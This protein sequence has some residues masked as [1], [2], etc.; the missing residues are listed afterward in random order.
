MKFGVWVKSRPHAVA[1]CSLPEG[2]LAH[3]QTIVLK[4]NWVKG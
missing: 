2:T 3:K 1:Y 4:G